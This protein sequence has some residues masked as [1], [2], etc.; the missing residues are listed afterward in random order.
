MAVFNISAS[1]DG[2]ASHI[3]RTGYASSVQIGEPVSP[4]D[5]IDKCHVAVYMAAMAVAGLTL[6]RTIEVHTVT[7]RIYRRAAFAQGDDAGAV[8]KE[9]S[10]TLAQITDNL[11]GDF[12]LGASMRNI[13]IAGQFGEPLGG[14]W[15]Y[16]D[17]GGTM[18]RIV[19]LRVPLVINGD[20]A[21]AT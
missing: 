7:V 11:I 2:I 21:T 19:D 4:P 18:H 16:V 6:S 17:L 5:T 9:L 13:D 8:E 3:Q 1:L 14:T 12:D 10:L 15:G 20:T